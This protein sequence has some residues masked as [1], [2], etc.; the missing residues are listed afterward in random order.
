M[1]TQFKSL[2]QIIKEYYASMGI[3][4][5]KKEL[6]TWSNKFTEFCALMGI[7]TGSMQKANHRYAFI[8]KDADFINKK[9]F[10]RFNEEPISYIRRGMYEK[11]SW[12]FYKEVES[13]VTSVMRTNGKDEEDRRKQIQ[14]IRHKTRWIYRRDILLVKYHPSQKTENFY[15]NVVSRYALGVDDKLLIINRVKNDVELSLKETFKKWED[16]LEDFY[17]ARTNDITDIKNEDLD[18]LDLKMRIKSDIDF[19]IEVDEE[20]NQKKKELLE[21][22]ARNKLT[23]NT[24]K[25]KL[26]DE[27]IKMEKKIREDVY[28]RQGI[29]DEIEKKMRKAES[30]SKSSEE[31]LNELLAQ[32]DENNG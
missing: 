3:E 22:E 27:I 7:F 24:I 19:L 32:Y 12:Y 26:Q 2:H 9:I 6:D 4:S 13:F 10:A 17:E 29:T 11:V 31:I 23:E 25:A 1:S 18:M 21:L 14:S 15:K 16:I 20:L 30:C 28:E 8:E 5:G